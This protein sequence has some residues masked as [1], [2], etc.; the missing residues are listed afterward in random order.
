[1]RGCPMHAPLP[2]KHWRR[3]GGEPC[4]H[5]GRHAGI[6]RRDSRTGRIHRQKQDREFRRAVTDS[7]LRK[8]LDP[9]ARV[10]RQEQQAV[11][12][13]ALGDYSY[14][15]S[16]VVT[17]DG[18]TAALMTL[19]WMVHVFDRYNWVNSGKQSNLGWGVTLSHAELGIC[20]SVTRGAFLGSYRTLTSKMI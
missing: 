19:Q 17:R 11:Q 4:Q 5:D 13:R 9:L 3:P 16:G 12:P 20:T 7:R 6:S 18:T 10:G 2:P 1:V 8:L 14:A 15:V